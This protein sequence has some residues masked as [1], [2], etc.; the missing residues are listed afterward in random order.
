MRC[1]RTAEVAHGH[2][3]EV[4]VVRGDVLASGAGTGSPADDL[5]P[6][7]RQLTGPPATAGSRTSPPPAPPT[8]SAGA[9][10]APWTPPAATSTRLSAA[11]G[12]EEPLRAAVDRG[13]VSERMALAAVSGGTAPTATASTG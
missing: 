6:A 1:V 12:P 5:D 8:R 11:R 13:E 10:R 9:P 2:R 4:V 7:Q 3:A